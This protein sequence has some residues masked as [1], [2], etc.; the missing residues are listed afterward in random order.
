MKYKLSLEWQGVS[1]GMKYASFLFVCLF[2][3]LFFVFRDGV[4]LYSPGCPGTHSV[5]Q[6]GLKLRNSPAS[7]SRVLGL[8]ACTTTPGS[9]A[10]LFKIASLKLEKWRDGWDR[11]KPAAHMRT[12]GTP[13]VS[14]QHMLGLRH[15][16]AA[17]V[18]G[19]ST[20]DR[21]SQVLHC[22]C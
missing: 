22:S 15:V 6:A 19:L 13:G 3:C 8:K 21:A 14:V 1:G 2:V 12:V 20:E 4:S 10:S 17:S 18:R 5:D 11:M 16:C 7:A 9:Y